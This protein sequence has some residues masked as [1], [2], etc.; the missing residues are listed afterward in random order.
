MNTKGKLMENSLN[1]EEEKKKRE[2]YTAVVVGVGGAIG[3]RSINIDIQ[4][5][6]YTTDE[7]AIGYLTLLK[8]KGQDQLRLK[9]EK[10]DVGVVRPS[11]SV[12]TDLAIAR[13]F[14]T[15]DGK[16]IRVLTARNMRFMELYHGGRSTDY[17]FTVIEIRL[18]KEGK[19][20][21]SIMGATQISFTQEG[22]LELESLGN[23]YARL[24]NVRSW[25]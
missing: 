13:G 14:E 17:P 25:D 24:V 2:I 16:V 21:G 15:P 20:E 23:Q 11:V 9:L 1:P 22:K 3:A 5:E 6:K 4:I 19:G 18:D 8:E 7:E 10:I 12:G